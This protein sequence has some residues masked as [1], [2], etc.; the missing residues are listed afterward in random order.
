MNSGGLPVRYRRSPL[1][2]HW[3]WTPTGTARSLRKAEQEEKISIIQFKL[4]ELKL[5]A[6]HLKILS[7]NDDNY[8]DNDFIL[9][10]TLLLFCWTYTYVRHLHMICTIVLYYGNYLYIYSTNQKERKYIV[11][12]LIEVILSIPTN[13]FNVSIPQ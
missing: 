4:F 9:H 10:C 1:P 8:D 2:P 7:Y 5:F 6:F 12:T 13:S 3:Q 11:D